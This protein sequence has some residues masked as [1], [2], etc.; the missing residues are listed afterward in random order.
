MKPRHLFLVLCLAGTALLASCG[1][2]KNSRFYVLTPH[3]LSSPETGEALRNLEGGPEV[4][5]GAVELPRY[6]SGPEI[7]TRDG[8]R[9]DKAEYDRWA[10]NLQDQFNRA[11]AINLAILIPSEHIIRFAWEY[12]VAADHFVTVSVVRFDVEDGQARLAA[13]W[14]IADG[15]GEPTTM[16][17]A[18]HT[19]PVEGEGYGAI[20]RALSQTLVDLSRDIAD[21]VRAEEKKAKDG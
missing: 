1:S 17:L 13:R 12:V 18:M 10:S 3:P 4:R 7:V 9:I 19:S 2:T 20:V 8:N 5:L 16:H 21:E 11:L 15:V 6:L 14:G